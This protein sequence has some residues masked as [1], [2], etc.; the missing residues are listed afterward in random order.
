MGTHS[1]DG[2][3]NGDTGRSAVRNAVRD[4]RRGGGSVAAVLVG[5]VTDTV[6][7][8]GVGTQ[9]VGLVVRSRAAAEVGGFV[10][11]AAEA[12][13]LIW[14]LVLHGDKCGA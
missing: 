8:V 5:A 14:K 9:A 2:G 11:Q 6:G 3:G 12:V 1:L 4:D 13:L 10:E 7:E